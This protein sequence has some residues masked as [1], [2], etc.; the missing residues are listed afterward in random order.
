MEKTRV[1]EGESYWY[2]TAYGDILKCDDYRTI[3]DIT[4]FRAGNYFHTKE[5]AEAMADDTER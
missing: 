5:E 2:I 3:F 4:L 1:K